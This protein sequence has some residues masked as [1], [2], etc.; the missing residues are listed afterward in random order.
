MDAEANGRL[1]SPVTHGE[2]DWAKLLSASDPTSNDTTLVTIPCETNSW[3]YRL[4]LPA[5]S[6]AVVRCSI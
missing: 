1:S 6:M 4:K 5:W 2:H 3:G